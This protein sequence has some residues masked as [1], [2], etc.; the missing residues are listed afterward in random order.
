MTSLPKSRLA[1]TMAGAVALLASGGAVIAPNVA[2]AA[3][4]Q[5]A[6]PTGRVNFTIDKT[7][8]G[9]GHGTPS[10]C[11]INSGNGYTTFGDNSATDGV[12]CAGDE[13]GYNINYNVT[14][15]DTPTT[16]QIRLNAPG[17]QPDGTPRSKADDGSFQAFSWNNS[18]ERFCKGG[19]G[20]YHTGTY[21][22]AS[23]VCTMTFPADASGT[24]Q[25][26]V[27]AQTHT[28]MQG[29]SAARIEMVSRTNNQW[30]AGEYTEADK[31]KTIYMYAID[32]ELDQMTEPTF[33]RQNGTPGITTDVSMYMI[34]IGSDYGRIKGHPGRY[35]KIKG[36][37]VVDFSDY[38]AG[39][40][41]TTPAGWTYNPAT[42][43]ATATDLVTNYD[44]QRGDSPTASGFANSENRSRQKFKVFVPTSSFD[45]T[46]DQK[47]MAHIESATVAPNEAMYITKN[48]DGKVQPGTSQPASF[49]TNKLSSS[50]GTYINANRQELS[51]VKNN[52]YVRTSV[53]ALAGAGNLTKNLYL[54]KNGVPD[55]TP[56]VKQ[57]GNIGADTP[58]WSVLDVSPS[59]STA[60]N[61]TR[62]CE[63]FVGPQDGTDKRSN[64]QKVDTSRQPVVQWWSEASNSLVTPNYTIE[65]GTATEH[66]SSSGANAI[67]MKAACNDSVPNWTSEPTATTNTVRVTLNEAATWQADGPLAGKIMLPMRSL[68][69][70]AYP[71]YPNKTSVSDNY[72]M[73]V[74]STNNWTVGIWAGINVAGPI[75]D[76]MAMSQGRDDKAHINAGSTIAHVPFS[77]TVNHTGVFTDADSD[78]ARLSFVTTVPSCV[79][80]ID[81]PEAMDKLNNYTVERPDWGADNLPCTTDDVHGW[82][83]TTQMKDPK[84]LD[85][86]NQYNFLNYKFAGDWAF[87]VPG[88]VKAGTQIPIKTNASFV[89]GKDLVTETP[90]R[91]DNNVDTVTLIVDASNTVG[92]SKF[93][94]TPTEQVG[95]DLKWTTA[96]FNR[97]QNPT[98]KSTFIDVLPYNGDQFGT[99]LSSP[100]SNVRIV[101]TDGTEGTTIYV[102]TD[103]PSTVNSDA[104]AASN[105]DGGSTNW[106]AYTGESVINDKQITAIKVVQDKMD[107]GYIGGINITA[108]TDG[109]KD[110]EV[111]FN[112]LGNANA[113]GFNLP[114]P[115]TAP[116]RSDLWNTWLSGTA[117]WDANKNGSKDADETKVFGGAKV[118]IM[119]GNGDPIGETTTKADGTWYFEGIPMGDYMVKITDRGTQIRSS[120]TQTEPKPDG[121][122]ATGDNGDVANPIEA[123]SFNHRNQSGLDFGFFNVIKPKLTVNKVAQGDNNGGSITDGTSITW[124]YVVTNEGDS[125]VENIKVKDN[126]GINVTCPKTELAAGQSMTCTGTGTVSPIAGG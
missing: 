100:L 25:A 58:F 8:D 47:W 27:R 29:T 54:D 102:T 24:G 90:G 63:S 107:V 1:A 32:P 104:R 70:D 5:V 36:S 78:N 87:S 112:R 86:D 91:Q 44:S 64:A 108:D 119:D 81:F 79:S 103:A 55:T 3:T 40:Q 84:T 94:T 7:Y 12:V 53:G 15:S 46:I 21:D 118:T 117:Y 72:S 14:Q 113:E 97:S 106:V 37:Y 115:A 125:L 16:V 49:D 50:Y 82:T 111:A 96:W 71:A 28:S 45:T 34:D 20:L 10:Q 61:N 74:S 73:D 41:V 62:F 122:Y 18:Y 4:N 48:Y 126:R 105:A 26:S 39:T 85:R 2:A 22:A 99:K 68:T 11:F 31:V 60:T 33:A 124:N 121:I 88:Y 19:T 13:V 123:L 75:N 65:Y 30:V 51:D 23:G 66:N 92:Q 116:V 43:K 56:L 17:T 42:R 76:I 59:S 9:T 38:P 57:W 110:G 114:I 98:G 80:N 93:T 69:S 109:S 101:N 77:Y 120:W 6:D 95:D 89:N 83:I 35:E 52:D 67:R